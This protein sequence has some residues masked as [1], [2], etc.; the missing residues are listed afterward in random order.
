MNGILMRVVWCLIVVLVLPNVWASAAELPEPG[1]LDQRVRYV[2]Y[3]QDDVT[4]VHVRRGVI[5]RIVLG[6]DEKIVIAATGF[7]V[8]VRSQK[9]NG[10]SGLTWEPIKCG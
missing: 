2:T 5:T 10:A 1:E 4:T 9:R 8:I 7:L 6:E 3:K